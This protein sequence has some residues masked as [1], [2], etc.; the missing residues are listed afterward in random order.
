MGKRSKERVFVLLLFFL[1][2]NVFIGRRV[3]KDIR[4]YM[5]VYMHV[6]LRV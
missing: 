5:R 6:Y 2:V 3:Y 4:V 1:I